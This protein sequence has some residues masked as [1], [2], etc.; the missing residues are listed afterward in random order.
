[1]SLPLVLLPGMMCDARLF[2]PQIVAFSGAREVTVG[3]I[4]GASDIGGLAEDVLKNAPQHF[5]L[6]GLS[7]GGIV[8]M[9]V[10]R[11]APDRVARLALLDTNPRA[12]LPA[13]RARR[14]PQIEAVRA[15][16][17]ARIMRDELKPNYIADTPDRA[18]ILDLCMAM[19]LDLGP[20]VFERQSIALRD[21]P[22]QQDTLRG[23]SVSALILCGRE[24]RLCPVERHELMHALIPGSDLVI[25][26]GAGHMP[27][28]ERPEE[29]TAALA[30]WLAD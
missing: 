8:A 15:G 1:M 6:A 28:L 20:E 29:T 9:E 25:V 23:V 5:A 7:M 24:D 18:A 19:A 12:E 14:G 10:I 3:D 11:R 30:R 22:D 21:R 4:T 13:V 2:G 17:L 27:T 16:H 26:E